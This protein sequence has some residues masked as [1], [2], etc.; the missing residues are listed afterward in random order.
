M[1]LSEDKC[2]FVVLEVSFLGV[3]ISA[4]GIRPNQN[5]VEAAGTTKPSTYVSVAIQLL[6]MVNHSARFQPHTLDVTAPI[7]A[8]LKKSAR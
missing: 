3:I 5:K 4:R 8:F 7:R 1:T 6:G 2:R